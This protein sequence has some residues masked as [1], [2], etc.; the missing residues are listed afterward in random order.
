MAMVDT[1]V[2]PQSERMFYLWLLLVLV[3]PTAA[4]LRRLL[5]IRATDRILSDRRPQ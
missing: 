5:P 1:C 3:V 4:R 2:E